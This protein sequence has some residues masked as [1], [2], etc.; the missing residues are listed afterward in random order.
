MIK[1]SKLDGAFRCAFSSDDVLGIAKAQPGRDLAVI[2]I[3][4]YPNKKDMDVMKAKWRQSLA[5]LGYHRLVILRSGIGMKVNR[6][7]VIENIETATP[8]A[9]ITPKS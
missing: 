8:M 6:L 4:P 9:S 3:D 7:R 2:V 1:P 5:E